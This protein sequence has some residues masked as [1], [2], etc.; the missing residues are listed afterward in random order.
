MFLVQGAKVEDCHSCLHRDAGRPRGSLGRPCSLHGHALVFSATARSS[1]FR[2][3]DCQLKVYSF[4]LL[5]IP[6]HLPKTLPAP[7]HP[8]PTKS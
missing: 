6:T 1:F 5:H 7:H 4:F 3:S 8:R 2:M